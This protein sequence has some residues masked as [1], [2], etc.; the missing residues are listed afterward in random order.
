MWTA[1][2]CKQYEQ[3]HC[4]ARTN[5]H[6][7]VSDWHVLHRLLHRVVSWDGQRNGKTHQGWCWEVWQAWTLISLSF[8]ALTDCLFIWRPPGSSNQGRASCRRRP[9]HVHCGQCH[10]PS[11]GLGLS[12]GQPGQAKRVFSSHGGGSQFSCDPGLAA[13]PLLASQVEAQH[14]RDWLLYPR[15]RCYPEWRSQCEQGFLRER[16]YTPWMNQW[17]NDAASKHWTEKKE[18][19]HNLIPTYNINAIQRWT[20]DR[21]ERARSAPTNPTWD[22]YFS[23]RCYFYSTYPNNSKKKL[24]T[25]FSF[26]QNKP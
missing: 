14:M 9:V 11:H 4:Q 6:L 22:I 17:M 8:F 26:T 15:D 3:R 1:K 23:K 21:E 5:G 2:Y 19:R 7:Q 10:G 18:T 16:I 24:P 12:R 20:I 13:Q 25:M